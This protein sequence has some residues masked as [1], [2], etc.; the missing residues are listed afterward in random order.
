[1][2]CHHCLIEFHPAE[3]EF[4]LEADDSGNWSIYQYICP[5]CEKSNIYLNHYR[6]FRTAD[7]NE[8]HLIFEDLIYPKGTSRAPCPPEV[9]E[10]LR[11]DYLEACLVLSDSPKASAALSRRCLQTLLRNYE[12]VKKS[13]LYSEI[14]DTINKN[15]LPTNLSE[16][17]H[18]VRVIGNFA[19]HPI[20]SKNSGEIIP[21][22]P[23]EAELNLDALE[24]LFDYYF[25][26]PASVQKKKEAINKKLRDAGKMTI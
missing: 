19:T 1:M 26:L 25:V 8:K 13:D 5:A 9:P 12:K 7:R 10:D 4:E 2:K 23:E 16:L 18:S 20:K 11:D 22:E 3:K 17:L 24:G 15:R 21:V 14:E 6:F